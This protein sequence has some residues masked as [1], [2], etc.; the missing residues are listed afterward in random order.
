LHGYTDKP[1]H[2]TA[3]CIYANNNAEGERTLPAGEK[4]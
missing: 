1:R 3:Y 4:L 2:I